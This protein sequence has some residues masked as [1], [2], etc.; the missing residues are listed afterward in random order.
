MKE[1]NIQP[2]ALDVMEGVNLNIEEVYIS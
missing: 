2:A 1:V